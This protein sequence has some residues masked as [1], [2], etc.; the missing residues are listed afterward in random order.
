M[1]AWG[2]S[3]GLGTPISGD[4]SATQVENSPINRAS[5]CGAVVCGTAA[6]G[7]L[8][9]SGPRVA[10]QARTLPVARCAC[11]RRTWAHVGSLSGDVGAP[12][13]TPTIRRKAGYSPRH[14]HS[15][16]HRLKECTQIQ[17]DSSPAQSGHVDAGIPPA[18][19]EGARMTPRI[20]IVGRLPVDLSRRVRAAAKQQRLSLN[21]F[22]IAALTKAVEAPR[23][24]TGA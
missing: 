2:A 16:A 21:A 7:P 5:I 3:V 19:P 11:V 4:T 20:Q 13:G 22:L 8:P 18:H 1:T 15:P 12:S 14:R 6:L 9:G 17:L 23:T 24:K 10:P